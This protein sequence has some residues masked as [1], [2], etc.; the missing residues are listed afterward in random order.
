M[1]NP[2]KDIS[3]K[4]QAF[5]GGFSLGGNNITSVHSARIP[6]LLGANPFADSP[7]AKAMGQEPAKAKVQQENLNPMLNPPAAGQSTVAEVLRSGIGLGAGTGAPNADA[8]GDAN[9]FTV[10]SLDAYRMHLWNRMAAQYKYNK[11]LDHSNN[12]NNNNMHINNPSPFASASAATSPSSWKTHSPPQSPPFGLASR[13]GPKYFSSP[14]AGTSNSL[15]AAFSGMSLSGKQPQSQSA[16]LSQRQREK[17]RE[18]AQTQAQQEALYATMASQTLVRRLGSA[19]WDAFS[20]SDSSSSSS[21]STGAA[22]SG[23]SAS[24]DAEKVRKVLEGKAVV[25]V[26]DVDPPTTPKI[27]AAAATPAAT[28]APAP[29]PAPARCTASLAGCLEESMRSL[30]L[31]KKH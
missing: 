27:P 29:A 17:E 12:N 10:R 15:A 26:V 13:L 30:S 8:F 18:Q 23:K 9:P 31:A 7:F 14:A 16:T 22:G 19:F 24:W 25:R 11:S 4:N 21:R 20:G 28:P 1:F 5:W 2:S 6:D 3:D